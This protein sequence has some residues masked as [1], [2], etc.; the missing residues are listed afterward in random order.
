M[1]IQLARQKLF[2]IAGDELTG[3][4]TSSGRALLHATAPDDFEYYL[5]GFEVV[6]G[7]NIVTDRFVMPVLPENITIN[8]QKIINIKK[9]A[10]GISSY[11]NN[12]F[13]PISISLNGTFGRRF[14]LTLGNFQSTDDQ[15]TNKPFQLNVKTGYGLAKELERI[16]KKNGQLDGNNV[17]FRINFYNY[18]FNQSFVVEFNNLQF[19]Q[20][21]DKNVMWYYSLN[22]TAVAPAEIGGFQSTFNQAL[23]VDT[24]NKAIDS[25]TRDA[26]N[27]IG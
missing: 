1:S 7:S 12:T 22:M 14:R 15:S 10:A 11:Q 13:E 23:K 6:N 27:L 5:M 21:Q 18:A 16:Y 3:A 25:L 17:P 2:D 20:S 9:T 8:N 19:R 24:A 4:I 26:R